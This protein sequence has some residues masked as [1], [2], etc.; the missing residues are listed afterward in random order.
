MKQETDGSARTALALAQM[1]FWWLVQQGLIPKAQAEQMLR[2][3]I[4]A[5][6][7]DSEDCQLAAAKL[8][9]VLQSIQVFLP[10]IQH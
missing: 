7:A 10:P 8:E 2:Q 4:R 5:N 6:E 3:A 1:I 9:A